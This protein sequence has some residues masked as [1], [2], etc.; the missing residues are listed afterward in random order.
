AE[1]WQTIK[2][3]QIQL[4]SAMDIELE[5]LEIDGISIGQHSEELNAYLE[6]AAKAL[7]GPDYVLLGDLLEYELA[8]RAELESRI[9]GLLE[10]R[11]RNLSA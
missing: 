4:S 2:A 5:T 6:E 10:E 7:E 8:P 3:R 9:V 1:I 11:R